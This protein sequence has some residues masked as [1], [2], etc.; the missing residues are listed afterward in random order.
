MQFALINAQATV[1]HVNPRTEKHGEDNK[2]AC[3]IKVEV[4]SGQKILDAFDPQLRKFL[5]RKPSLAGEQP[6]LPLDAESDLTALKFPKLLRQRWDG[7]MKDY[8]L[9]IP[10]NVG[11]DNKLECDA[12]NANSRNSRSRRSRVAR[13]GWCSISSATRTPSRSASC[14]SCCRKRS[15]S[16]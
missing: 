7:S 14:A 4:D 8:L 16:R 15:N 3:D 11:D 10:F 5:F 2:L 1:L 6:A 13:C 9:E 12:R